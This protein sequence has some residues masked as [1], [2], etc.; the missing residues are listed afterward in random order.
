MNID[1]G[2]TGQ[3][4]RPNTNSN[5]LKLFALPLV[6]SMLVACANSDFSDLQQYIQQVKARPAGR[7]APVPE[8]E[9]YE[10]FAYSASE[11]RDPF[12]MFDSEASMAEGGGS[13]SRTSLQPNKTRNKEALEQYPLDTLHYV[14]DLQRDG[15]KWAIIT[16]PDHLVHRVKIGN[17]L[18]TNYGKIVSITETRIGIKEIIQDGMG[19][20]IER[21]AELSL[22][23]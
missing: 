14:G 21:E 23:E 22:S 18:G 4:L 7:I 12:K 19:G 11:L 5:M 10:T 20:W 8:F 16:S 3:A 1:T 2:R 17:H 9:T 6:A 15:E 13:V